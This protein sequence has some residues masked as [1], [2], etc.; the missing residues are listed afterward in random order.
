MILQYR[1]KFVHASVFYVI[2]V[3]AVQ[4][5]KYILIYF[6]YVDG[7]LYKNKTCH[8]TNNS[9]TD[10]QYRLHQNLVLHLL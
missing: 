8:N 1:I 10:L 2:V 6:I 7:I 9:S 4:K 5:L 3:V